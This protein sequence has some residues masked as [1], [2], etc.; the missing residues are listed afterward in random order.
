M[1]PSTVL[2]ALHVTCLILTATTDQILLLPCFATE[3][4]E[5]QSAYIT[6]LRSQRTQMIRAQAVQVQKW[7]S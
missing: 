5:I 4:T 1:V 2:S 7:S 3:E 6:Y